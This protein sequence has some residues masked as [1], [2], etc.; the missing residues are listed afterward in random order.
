V[1]TRN[2]ALGPEHAER[3]IVLLRVREATDQGMLTHS[4]ASYA[5]KSSVHNA[6]MI[7]QAV[8]KCNLTNST[9]SIAQAMQC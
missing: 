9:T 5:Y 2:V 8:V 6:S 7:A 4:S 3:P 1:R